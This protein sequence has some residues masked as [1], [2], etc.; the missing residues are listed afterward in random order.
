MARLSWNEIEIRASQFVSSWRGHTYEKGDSQSFW[1]EFL[2]IY[3]IDRRRSGALFE[4]PTKKLSGKQGFIDLFWPGKLIAEQKSAGR[5][6]DKA[7][8]QAL[9]YLYTLPDHDLPQFI[10][11]CDFAIFQVLE[12]ATGKKATF[13][14]EQFP[15]RVKLFAFL[16]DETSQQ[17]VEEDPVNRQAAEGMA[18]LHNQ[19]RDSRYTGHDLELLLVRLVFALFADDAQI[20]ERGTFERYIRTRTNIDGSDLGMHLNSIFEVLN[21]PEHERQV[22]LDRDLRA[23]PYING[24]LFERTMRTPSC[25]N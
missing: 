24:G 16:I 23:F 18:R 19:L 4:H 12:L 3:G 25:I 7:T 21:T 11:A 2:D 5:G 22:A 10:V 14:L 6:L 20:F 1:T 9:D 13:T 15:T 17:T 8:S